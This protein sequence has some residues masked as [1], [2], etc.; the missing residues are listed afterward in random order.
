[1]NAFS[2]GTAEARSH[3]LATEGG[4]QRHCQSVSFMKRK[5][6]QI[7]HI[8]TPLSSE[9][10][11]SY[12]KYVGGKT[13]SSAFQFS[14]VPV[15]TCDNEKQTPLKASI[16]KEQ[17]WDWRGREKVNCFG[18]GTMKQTQALRQVGFERRI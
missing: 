17:W 12:F 5:Q 13:K 14:R 16:K 15:S 7:S 10:G 1:M 2:L 18:R 9:K 3:S 4:F 8:A 6:Q 11:T